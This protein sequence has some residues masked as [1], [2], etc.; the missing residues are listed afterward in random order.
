MTLALDRP[1]ITRNPD[2]IVLNVL[3]GKL[4]AQV[5]GRSFKH[6]LQ[7]SHIGFPVQSPLERL[8]RARELLALYASASCV[9]TTRLHCALPCLAIGT[10]VLLIN[11]NSDPYR[12][13]GL[14]ELV[15][16]CSIEDYIT[17]GS[18]YDINQP[19]PNPETH[20]PL[21]DALIK[22]VE[23]FVA[24]DNGYTWR[25]NPHHPTAEDRA[26]AVAALT[27]TPAATRAA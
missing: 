25:P 3:P 15:H 14:R 8:H 1:A 4:L 10:P 22:R 19:P 9:V 27:A 12:F 11:Y 13:A 17:F 18:S 23:T 24:G 5:R 2:L 20:L 16:N 26:A 6:V 7:T 21:R